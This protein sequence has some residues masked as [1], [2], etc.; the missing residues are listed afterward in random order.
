MIGL[1]SS[2]DF[3]AA[4]DKA[5]AAESDNPSRSEMIRRIVAEWLRQKGFL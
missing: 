1:R 3:T 5:A 2:P 4:I